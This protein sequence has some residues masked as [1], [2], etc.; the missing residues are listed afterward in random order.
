MNIIHICD[1]EGGVNMNIKHIRIDSGM[2]QLQLAEKLDVDRSTVTKWETG[3]AMP[4]VD[5][6]IELARVL[7]CTIDDLLSE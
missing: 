4:R 2:S 5:K 6:L 1:V 3:V 7:C